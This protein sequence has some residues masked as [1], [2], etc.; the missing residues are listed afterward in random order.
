[1]AHVWPQAQ[2][3][4][5]E[6]QTYAAVASFSV[7]APAGQEESLINHQQVAMLTSWLAGCLAGGQR[8]L[9]GRQRKAV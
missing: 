5:V 2:T 9:A 1:M 4:G 7:R 3:T 6:L 8:R